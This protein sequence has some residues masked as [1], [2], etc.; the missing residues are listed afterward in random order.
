MRSYYAELHPFDSSTKKKFRMLC[1][2]QSLRS[3]IKI[4]F[5]KIS[6]VFEVDQPQGEI[7]ICAF[8]VNS[9]YQE[10]NAIKAKVPPDLNLEASHSCTPWALF[11]CHIYSPRVLRE[12]TSFQ[13]SFP[14]MSKQKYVVVD[15]G[16]WG[17][18]VQSSLK[19]IVPD[20]FNV[21][22]RDECSLQ[23]AHPT[24]KRTMLFKGKILAVFGKLMFF[25]LH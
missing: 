12:L 6:H 2:S 14:N 22:E 5:R 21:N 7:L 23:G 19:I 18:D 4:S 17:L 16:S 1:R 13:F 10:T 15:W 24:T 9:S 11:C 20:P 8:E 3:G 25:S